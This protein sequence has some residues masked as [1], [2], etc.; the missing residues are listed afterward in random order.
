MFERLPEVTLL[1]DEDQHL[2]DIHLAED[3]KEGMVHRFTTLEIPERPP[4]LGITAGEL[5]GGVFSRGNHHA[6]K[7]CQ[8]C[9]KP[10]L[11]NYDLK[12]IATILPRTALTTRPANLWRCRELLPVV[13]DTAIV[14]LGE[15][16]YAA[17][18]S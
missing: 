14:T 9:G 3:V 8:S 13:Q 11:V 17:C 1:M 5:H 16:F 18:G 12:R 4:A 10:L 6:Y 2:T 15:G 7:L